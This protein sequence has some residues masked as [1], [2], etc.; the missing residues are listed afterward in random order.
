LSDSLF[1]A[2]LLA[3]VWEYVVTLLLCTPFE[4]SV[5]HAL[6]TVLRLIMATAEDEGVLQ[7]EPCKDVCIVE[8]AEVKQAHQGLQ[9][10]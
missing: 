2:E 7:F 9:I 4:P 6:R 8:R 5:P 1:S 3:A 10:N